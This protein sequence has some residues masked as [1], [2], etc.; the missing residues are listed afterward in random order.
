MLSFHRKIQFSSSYEIFDSSKT[1][2]ENTE[3]FGSDAGKKLAANFELEV[4]FAL[5]GTYEVDPLTGMI[6]NLCDVDRWL[7]NLKK[8]LTADSLNVVL[9]T[10]QPTLDV[11]IR[12]ATSELQ[13]SMRDE[14]AAAPSSLKGIAHA[15]TRSTKVTLRLQQLSIRTELQS[16]AGVVA[17]SL[18]LEC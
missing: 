13:R 17:S 12:F 8:K 9:R 6:V 1:L 7:A 10:T 5:D 4:K 11:L 14:A 18:R 15:D 2:L 3:M 16:H